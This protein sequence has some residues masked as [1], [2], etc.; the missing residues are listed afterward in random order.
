MPF[1]SKNIGID[2]GTANTRIY[3]EEDG[4]VLDEASALAYDTRYKKIVAFGNEA[5]GM[6]GRT[7]SFIEVIYPVKEGVIADYH[8][9]EAMLR[10]FLER[11]VRTHGLFSPKVVIGVPAEA[12]EVEKRAVE[13]AILS[14]GARQVTVI[15]EPIASGMGLGL[16]VKSGE[17]HMIVD[18]GA[19][20]TEVAVISLMGIATGGSIRTAGDA[21]DNAIINYIKKNYSL[22]IGT[23]T[24]RMIKENV[25]SATAYEG[26]G[27]MDFK[28]RDLLTGL[29]K[30]ISVT[31]E[32]IRE[33]LTDYVVAILEC[34][35]RVLEKT[36]PELIGDITANGIHLVGGGSLLKGLSEYITSQTGLKTSV[37]QSA[38]KC[39]AEGIGMIIAEPGALKNFKVTVKKNK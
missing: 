25:G 14:C 22:L 29:P 31:S 36:P 21:M 11:T 1:F 37:A 15:D 5:E 34:I 9:A 20:T 39:L 38:D 23:P 24:A 2:L 3:T 4:I 12:T 17:A 18:I 32:Q 28:G 8:M 13:D 10:C 30:T 35:R 19:G 26:E 33:A 16:D 7:P 6:L 27:Q